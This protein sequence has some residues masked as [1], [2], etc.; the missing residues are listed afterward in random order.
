M[1]FLIIPKSKVH[2]YEKQDA[3]IGL[4]TYA[5]TSQDIFTVYR[6]ANLNLDIEPSIIMSILHTN[7]YKSIV[8]I[9]WLST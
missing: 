6:E 8:K 2:I 9:L 3:S 4:I 7:E 5:P 1:I